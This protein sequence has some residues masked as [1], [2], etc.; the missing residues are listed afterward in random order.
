M[1]KPGP[2]APWTQVS[3]WCPNWRVAE[4]VAVTD[5]GPFL[6]AAEREAAIDRWWFTRK[7]PLW[8]LRV[9]PAPQRADHAVSALHAHLEDLTARRAVQRWAATIYE[10][11]VHAFGG[12]DAMEV[13]H[14][15][16]HLDSHHILRHLNQNGRGARDHRRE[17]CLLLG[18]ALMRAAA[19]DRYEQGDIWAEVAAHRISGAADLLPPSADV[20]AAVHRLTTAHT[21][22]A[23]SPLATS[24]GWAAAFAAAGRDLAGMAGD[25][26]L[27]RGL[28][29]VLAHH[30]LLAWNRAGIPGPHQGVLA[31]TA[32]RL[33]F[34]RRSHAPGTRP[35][36]RVSAVTT[37]NATAGPSATP[38]IEALREALIAQI[39]ALGMLRSPRVEAA[40]RAVPRHVF[41]PET[42]LETAYSRQ[43]VITK[44]DRD[45]DVISSASSPSLVTAML[46]QLDVQ[47]GHRVLEIGAGTGI[48]AALLAELVGPTGHVTT[49]DIDDEVTAAARDHLS[50]AGYPQVEV[51]CADGADGHPANAPYDRI[52]VTAGAWDLAPAWWR[53]LVDGGRL[54]VPLRLHEC[55]LTRSVAFDHR[56]GGVDRMDSAS[57]LVCGFLDMRGVI[58]YDEQS[59]PLADGVVLRVNPADLDT[60][61]ASG[62][63]SACASDGSA[64][65]QA[66][67]Y[68]ARQRWTGITLGHR[69][70]VEHLDLW[71]VTSGVQF[72]RLIVTAAA[73][74]GG[75]ATPALRWSGA[76]LHEAGNIA[77]LT[78]R[79]TGDATDELGVVAHGPDAAALADQTV[80]LLK[81]W[82]AQQPAQ[83]IITAYP[84]ATPDDAMASGFVVQRPDSR[85]VIA[86]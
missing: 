5:L 11:E 18:H 33:V 76:A 6:A 12:D 65:A 43:V 72:A 66:M 52:I 58:A 81:R 79:P 3:M 54:V 61:G 78:L 19:Q 71:L 84:A 2:A 35:R 50:D 77:Y 62:S 41:L 26:R 24:P 36:T 56:P 9:Q 85:L 27:T 67:T 55:G 28:R 86:W 49:I 22:S 17:L 42:P 68:P 21:P 82:H 30:I 8:R 20:I 53:Q 39:R 48:N 38:D 44:R 37:F 23:H 64:L 4:R 46:E 32:A 75:V 73:R 59:V 74:A 34:H 57:A 83:P 15:L 10:P 16:F 63:A 70:P 7:G 14:T 60:T 29:A 45:G 51:I 1:S 40:F 31:D 69:D 25:G 80:D 13:A 47:P